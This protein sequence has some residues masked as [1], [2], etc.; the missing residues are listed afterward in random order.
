VIGAGKAYLLWALYLAILWGATWAFGT[1]D[2]ETVIL[3]AAASVL[4]A[5]TGLF[6]YVRGRRGVAPEGDTDPRHDPDLSL[7]T[8]WTAV[9]AA[10]LLLSAAYGPWLALTAG[11]ML[12]V[13]IAGLIRERRSARP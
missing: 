8:A 2:R 5:L 6:A 9:S 11:G 13:G 1:P 12:I 3:L 10:L 4:C 7:A